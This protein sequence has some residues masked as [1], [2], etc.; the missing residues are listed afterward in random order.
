MAKSQMAER[1]KVE[2]ARCDTNIVTER[3]KVEWPRCDTNT[4]TEGLYK[5]SESIVEKTLIIL[6]YREWI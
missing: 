1:L 4:V 6:Y 2:W 3:P 5:I